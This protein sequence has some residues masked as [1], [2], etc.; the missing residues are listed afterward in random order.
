M[1]DTNDEILQRIEQAKKNK[2]KL[3]HITNKSELSIEDRFKISLCRHFVQYLN[4]KKLKSVDLAKLIGI[5][6]SR[7]SEIVN[8]KITKHSIEHLL[9]YLQKL[10]THS[11]AIREYLH[12]IDAA[13]EAPNMSAAK[14][15]KISTSIKNQY[16]RA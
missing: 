10:A 5:P 6:A 8:Y 4:E 14:A 1:K 16:V 2:S 11:P 15:R 3:T 12:L 7:V 9:G 13:M